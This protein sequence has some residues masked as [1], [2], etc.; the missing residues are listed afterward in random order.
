MTGTSAESQA[1]RQEQTTVYTP[2]KYGQGPQ[3]EKQM[4]TAP[5]A[6]LRIVLSETAATLSLG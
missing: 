2:L 5:G 1:G 6:S 3:K 4:E